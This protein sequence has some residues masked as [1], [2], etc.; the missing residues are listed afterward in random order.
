MS[1]TNTGRQRQV[2]LWGA[3]AVALMLFWAFIWDPLSNS[4]IALR[5]QLVE[6]QSTALWLQQI[7]PQVIGTS[8]ESRGLPE[9]K[10][11]LRLADETLRAAGMA[12]AIERIEPGPSGEVRVW[13]REASFDQLS[14]WLVQIANNYAVSATQLN[15]S[16]A[17]ET[18]LVNVRLEIL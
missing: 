12:A 4:R 6:Q 7:Q 11:L 5:Q 17:D 18:G 14:G 1:D 16:R 9:N 3:V 10:S 13:L 8:R 2:L 15:A